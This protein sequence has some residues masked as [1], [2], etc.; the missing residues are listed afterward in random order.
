MKKR[1]HSSKIGVF[2]ALRIAIPNGFQTAID[3][4]KSARGVPDT[5]PARKMTI[6]ATREVEVEFE[7]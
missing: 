2:D 1:E 3:L 6:K 4:F 7:S 5:N